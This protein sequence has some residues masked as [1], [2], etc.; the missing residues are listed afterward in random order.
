LAFI[1]VK[2]F[3][4]IS[5][6]SWWTIAFVRSSRVATGGDV[7]T[8]CFASFTLVNVVTVTH[9]A[10]AVKTKLTDACWLVSFHIVETMGI[11]VTAV[12]L[13]AALVE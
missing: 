1:N 2:T 6:I 8:F 9:R 3:A 12:V 5:N 4:T 11:V 13:V 7:G 10:A